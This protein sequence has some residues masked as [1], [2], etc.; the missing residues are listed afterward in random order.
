MRTVIFGAILLAVAAAGFHTFHL[1]LDL[2]EFCTPG[3]RHLPSDLLQCSNPNE[4][5][6]AFTRRG[7]RHI[8]MVQSLLSPL[9]PLTV[10]RRKASRYGFNN[11]RAKIFTSSVFWPLRVCRVCVALLGFAFAGIWSLRHC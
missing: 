4:R 6:P 1:L 5:S 9:G 2:L 7:P 3:Q 8:G 11:M 10:V